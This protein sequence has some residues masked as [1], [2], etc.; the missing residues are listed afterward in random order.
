MAKFSIPAH[1]LIPGAEGAHI[2][3]TIGDRYHLLGEVTGQRIDGAGFVRL[4]VKHFN[5]EPWP[6]T[7]LAADVNVLERD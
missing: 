7:P 2:A 6:V 4:R 3:Y 1:G 5:G